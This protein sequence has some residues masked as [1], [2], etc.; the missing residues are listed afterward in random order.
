MRNLYLVRHGQVDFPDHIPR[1]I[2]RT[3]LPL[4][5][6]GRK[7]GRE[8]GDYFRFLTAAGVPVYASP[9]KRALETAGL[10]AG[11]GSV[12]VEQGLLELDMGEWENMPRADLKK[13][14]ESQP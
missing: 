12:C 4:S 6:K 2:G 14:L 5:E 8:L 1:C 10:L 11:D 13:A 3:D 9:L 7:Q